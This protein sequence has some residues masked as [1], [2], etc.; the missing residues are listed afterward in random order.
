[1]RVRAT[2]LNYRDQAI[3]AGR[4][5]GGALKRDTDRAVRR[6]GRGHRRGRRAYAL[7]LPV[8]RSSQPFSVDPAGMPQAAPSALGSPLDGTLTEQVVLYEG[9][10]VAL[11]PGYSFE[12]GAT[13]PCA[14][15]TAWH[16]LTA[17]G[18]PIKAGDS[19][20]GAR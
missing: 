14:A 13:L 10:L 5:L 15:L 20:L 11:P 9:G 8:I 19:V 3:I 2:S 12:E 17:A 4:Y 7:R 1:M 6:R 16:A 18:R